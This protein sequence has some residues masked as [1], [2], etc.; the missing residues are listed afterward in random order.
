M[1]AKRIFINAGAL[2]E[3]KTPNEVI[4][5]LAH[6]TGHIAGGHLSRLREQLANAQ[7]A[8]ILAMLLGIGG[9]VAAS[10]GGGQGNIGGNPAAAILGPQETIRR[11][12]LSYVRAQ[13]EQA[14]RGGVKFLAATGQSAK[15]MYETFKRLAR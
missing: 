15:G 9:M 14:D 5:V 8:S 7:A 1:D 4:G 3:A 13:E 11:T 12:M 2:M 6:E 10:R